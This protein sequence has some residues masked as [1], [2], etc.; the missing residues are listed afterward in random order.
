MVFTMVAVSAT[1]RLPAG[2]VSSDGQVSRQR[3]AWTHRGMGHS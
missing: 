3:R 1:L 2:D